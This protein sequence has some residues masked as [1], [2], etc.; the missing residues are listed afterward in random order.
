MLKHNMQ[1]FPYIEFKWFLLDSIDIVNFKFV[2][3]VLW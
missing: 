2:N 3:V 1:A